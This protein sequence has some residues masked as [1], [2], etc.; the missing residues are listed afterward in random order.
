MKEAAYCGK[1]ETILMP[2]RGFATAHGVCLLQ[3]SLAS[4]VANFCRQVRRFLV[5]FAGRFWR[6]ILSQ[7]FASPRCDPRELAI[8]DRR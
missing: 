5:A 3:T 4:W 8:D 6:A 7:S 1:P 2:T